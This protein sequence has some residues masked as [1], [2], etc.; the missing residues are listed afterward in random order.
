[1]VRDAT[2]ST[3]PEGGMREDEEIEQ[4]DRE[5]LLLKSIN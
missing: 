1:M 3:K 5:N 4:R 2:L